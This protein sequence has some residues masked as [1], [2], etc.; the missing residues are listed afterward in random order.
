MLISA[1]SLLRLIG[2]DTSNPAGMRVFGRISEEILPMKEKRFSVEQIVGMLRQRRT[3]LDGRP[4]GY[5][6]LFKHS[7]LQVGI[8]PSLH[9]GDRIFDVFANG[10]NVV[11][12]LD[13]AAAAGGLLHL[14][15]GND[16]VSF[17]RSE[18]PCHPWHLVRNDVD[19]RSAHR[20]TWTA[21]HTSKV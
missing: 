14:Y 11:A 13:V 4:P 12:N 16:R 8:L 10:Q 20:R 19:T 3:G 21:W 9:P 5:P 17:G 15:R 6:A 7:A 2:A 18:R 1:D